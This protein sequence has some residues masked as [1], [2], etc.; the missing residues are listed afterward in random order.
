[1]AAAPKSGTVRTELWTTR[2]GF[3]VRV[4]LRDHA[5]RIVRSW[6]HP[7]DRDVHLG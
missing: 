6:P 1:M 2:K 3:R 5:G 7:L 4:T